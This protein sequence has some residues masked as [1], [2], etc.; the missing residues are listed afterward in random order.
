MPDSRSEA[1]WARTL[2]YLETALASVRVVEADCVTPAEAQELAAWAA[3]Q[4]IEVKRE[5]TPMRCQSVG[6][7]C[8]VC[9]GAEPGTLSFPP[10]GAPVGQ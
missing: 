1:I 6:G 4:G 10:V 7:V 8:S 2:G 3:K 5:R 9:Y